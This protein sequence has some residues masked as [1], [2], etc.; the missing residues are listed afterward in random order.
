MIIRLPQAGSAPWFWSFAAAV[1]TW[2]VAIT[3]SAGMG[4]TAMITAAL[5][6]SVFSVLVGVGQMFVIASGPGNIDLS[7]PSAIALGG[8]VA[9]KLMAGANALTA[10]GLAAACLVGIVVGLCN[11]GLIRA[12]KVP[13]IIAT[14]AMSFLLE[15]VAIA[16]GRG[17]LVQPP[18]VLGWVTTVRALGVPVLPVLGMLLTGALG[19]V[20]HRTVYGQSVLAIGQNT[21]AAWLAGFKIGRVRII[22]YALS[23]LLAGLCGAL[24]ASFSGGAALDMGT[25][26]L[27]AS[28]AIVVIGGTS[29]SG[30]RANLLGI[31]GAALFLYLL[32]SM[33]NSLG[34]GMGWRL[35]LNGLII[36]IVIVVAGGEKWER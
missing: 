5:S 19:V 25:E 36:V 2:L 9:M 21:R 26:Y 6:F 3:A 18:P 13:P 12:L 23:G 1:A 17:L 24:L 27:M 4:A 28:I 33:L 35:V 10:E 8:V 14:L 34:F 31:W 7:I 15:S 20:L 16:Y 29:A 30:G 11:A 22:T 32:R